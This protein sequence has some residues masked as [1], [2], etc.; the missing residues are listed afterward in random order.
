MTPKQALQTIYQAL[1]AINAPAEAHEHL[2]S[3]VT[4]LEQELKD[5][6]KPTE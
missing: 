3:C 2:K 5:K 6:E 1:R 4:L